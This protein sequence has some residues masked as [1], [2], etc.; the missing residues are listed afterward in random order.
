MKIKTAH[1]YCMLSPK[2]YKMFHVKP[3][4]FM[5]ELTSKHGYKTTL[6]TIQAC[7]LKT[8]CDTTNLESKVVNIVYHLHFIEGQQ[9]LT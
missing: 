8:K 4:K 7:L 2:A 1:E 5:C 3:S 6:Q 9:V